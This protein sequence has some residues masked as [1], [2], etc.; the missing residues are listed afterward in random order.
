MEFHFALFPCSVIDD[1]HFTGLQRE[2][3][4]WVNNEEDTQAYMYMD[5]NYSKAMSYTSSYR[6]GPLNYAHVHNACE[7]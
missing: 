5:M 6:Y 1:L 2:Y 4:L 7:K 3:K